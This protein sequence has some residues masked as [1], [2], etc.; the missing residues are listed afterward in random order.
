MA[1]T[2]HT[3]R[4]LTRFLARQREEG[5]GLAAASDLLEL[6]PLG[7]APAPAYLARFRC[8]GLVR[9]GA[10]VLEHD[11]FLVG[12]HFPEWYLRRFETAR[13]LTFI[14]PD[15]IF[16]PNI[17]KPFICVG[18]MQPGTGLVDLLYQV[19]EIITYRNVEM[20]EPEA[21]NHEACVW[22]RRNVHRFPV[23]DRPLKR[24][25]LTAAAGGQRTA[26]APRKASPNVPCG[27]PRVVEP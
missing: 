3:D 25:V 26:P 6:T 22:A 11:D 27:A 13:V 5:M 17:R 23:D 4:V 7:P 24:R 9:R 12:I 1:H 16:H 10:Q 8:R 19:F 18:R 15:D 20:R 2:A 14:E 21:L